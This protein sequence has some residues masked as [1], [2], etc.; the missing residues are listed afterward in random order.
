[1]EDNDERRFHVLWKTRSFHWRN[2][3][4]LEQRLARRVSRYVLGAA[5]QVY[6]NKAD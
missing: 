2:G 5:G 6:K 4:A 1:M 3:W